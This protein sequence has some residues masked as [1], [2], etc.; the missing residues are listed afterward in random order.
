MPIKEGDLGKPITATTG[1]GVGPYVATAERTA[2]DWYGGNV[3]QTSGFSMP[4]AGVN[5]ASGTNIGFPS[6][7]ALL[8]PPIVGR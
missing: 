4:F 5:I 7:A 8:G 6:L 3:A 2:V 1:F